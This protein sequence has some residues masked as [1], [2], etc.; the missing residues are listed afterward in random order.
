MKNTSLEREGIKIQ[1]NINN[2]LNW[3]RM[4]KGVPTDVCCSRMCVCVFVCVCD[5]ANEFSLK[6][7][8]HCSGKY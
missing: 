2:L 5:M 8:A 7:Q 1:I 3:R 4:L 6:F